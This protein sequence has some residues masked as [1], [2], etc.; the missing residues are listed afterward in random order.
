MYSFVLASVAIVAV[1]HINA[2]NLGDLPVCAQIAASAAIIQTGCAIT[3]IACVCRGGEFITA[4]LEQ[5]CDE[6]EQRATYAFATQLCAIAGVKLPASITALAAANPTTTATIAE[7]LSSLTTEPVPSSL[8]EAP[9]S[10]TP[11]PYNSNIT[12]IITNTTTVVPTSET[13]ISTSTLAT[14]SI[15]ITIPATLTPVGK[16]NITSIPVILS[17]IPPKSLSIM[18][19]LSSSIQS[20][21]DAT[22]VD[23]TFTSTPPPLPSTITIVSKSPT[24][25][26][27]PSTS[28]PSDNT[29]TTFPLSPTTFPRTPRLPP[30]T[31][32]S[33]IPS[34]PGTNLT[35]STS[36][37]SP[38]VQAFQPG[39][40]APTPPGRSWMGFFAAGV[41]GGVVALLFCAL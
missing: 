4:I 19:A 14:S 21:I 34:P 10:T 32:P 22:T 37:T 25:R 2:Q 38:S 20:V 8:S 27:L 16:P 26:S 28:T 31:I 6:T 13:I 29:P 36:P 18:S 30:S 5:E 7:T 39:S 23:A 11:P 24:V 41:S 40:G 3:D 35:N 12:A 17:T 9:I 1:R 15:P 33:T